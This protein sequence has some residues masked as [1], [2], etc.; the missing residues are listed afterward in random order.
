M[1]EQEA[2]PVVTYVRVSTRDP[3]RQS[4][5]SQIFAIQRF[6]AARRYRILRQFAD[7]MSGAERKRPGLDDLLSQLPTLAHSGCTALV[8][9][10]LDRLSRGGIFD[11]L[12]TALLL[13]DAGLDLVS[14]TEPIDTSNPYGRLFFSVAACLAEIERDRLRERVKDGMA[15]AMAAGKHCGRPRRNVLEADLRLMVELRD[16]GV[17]WNQIHQLTNEQYTIGT[18]R[19]RVTRFQ[20]ERA[21]A[22]KRRVFAKKG[23]TACEQPPSKPGT[24]TG[25]PNSE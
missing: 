12:Q 18:I 6:T 4:Y 11:L 25:S 7:R 13:K 5:E 23:V 21:V 17:S 16:K 8:V 9:Y 2:V 22:E 20:K 24:T 14:V 3:E 19:N 1:S 10:K 15:A